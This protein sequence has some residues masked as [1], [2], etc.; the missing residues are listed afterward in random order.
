MRRNIMMIELPFNFP[1]R[2]FRSPMPFSN[3]DGVEVWQ[4]YLEQ[5]INIVIVLTEEQEYLVYAKRD[6]PEFYRANG[7]DVLH[8]PVPDFGIPEDLPQW[9]QGLEAA[10]QA[11]KDGKNVAVHCLA[12]NG[13]TGTFL[14][15]LA[16]ENLDMTGDQAILWV[17][18]SIPGAMESRYQEE[19]VIK[20]LNSGK[21]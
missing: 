4:S 19:F 15:C 2:I 17:R 5:E 12:G 9:E 6:L 21:E 18:E 16:K 13:R 7:L 10:A 14:A 20:Y 8:I 11:A 3:F 1:G